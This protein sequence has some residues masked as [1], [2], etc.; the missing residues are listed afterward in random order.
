MTPIDLFG[1]LPAKADQQEIALLVAA[2]NA[3][4]ELDGYPGKRIARRTKEGLWLEITTDPKKPG[5]TSSV[6]MHNVSESGFAFWCKH[7]LAPRLSVWVREFSED[8]S[9]PWIPAEVTHCTVGIRGFLVGCE[10]NA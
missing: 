9:R 5:S 6:A 10:F 1:S 4:G 2:A 3:T 8:D 7:K